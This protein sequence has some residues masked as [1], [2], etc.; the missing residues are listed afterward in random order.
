MLQLAIGVAHCALS[1]Q[2]KFQVTPNFDVKKLLQVES[3]LVEILLADLN[4]PRKCSII[5]S[6][7]SPSKLLPKTRICVYM[8]Q[9]R[10]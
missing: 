8:K 6:S 2:E 3:N 1:L 10:I 4:I 5:F 9:G 7:F